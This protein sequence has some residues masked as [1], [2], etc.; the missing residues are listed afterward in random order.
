MKVFEYTGQ[1]GQKVGFGLVQTSQVYV[2]TDD[3]APILE[4]D[5]DFK[6]LKGKALEEADPVPA[7]PEPASAPA[8]AP[9]E[10]SPSESGLDQQIIAFTGAA[11]AAS[12]KSR[13]SRSGKPA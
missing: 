4:A 10:P 7:W 1:S 13:R 2:V 5:A 3:A 12:A 6:Q 9:T 8:V 11:P